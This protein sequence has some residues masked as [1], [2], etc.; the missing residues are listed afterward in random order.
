MLGLQESGE[1]DATPRPLD[2]NTS[3]ERSPVT[4]GYKYYRAVASIPPSAITALLK[5]VWHWR[6]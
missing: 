3:G 2:F 4:A 5:G 6:K 1:G